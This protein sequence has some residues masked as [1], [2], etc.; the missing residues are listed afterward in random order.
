[1][2]SP[3]FDIQSLLRDGR[4]SWTLDTAGSS[5]EFYVKHFWGAITVHPRFERLAG[6]GTISDDGIVTG[7]LRLE[8]GS[9]T[10]K[11]KKRDEHLRSAEVFDVERHPPSR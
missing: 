7:A 1:M 9:L 2:T 3:T 11:V 4:G 8:A 5:A 6:E 10:T